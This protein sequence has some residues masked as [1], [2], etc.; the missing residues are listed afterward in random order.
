MEHIH[1]EIL[2]YLKVQI[3]IF[4]LEEKDLIVLQ[5]LKM[6]ILQLHGMVEAK[7]LVLQIVMMEVD[8]VEEHPMF[9]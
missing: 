9:V 1:L 5:L 6:F 7:V 2:D 3:F 8:L 4:I